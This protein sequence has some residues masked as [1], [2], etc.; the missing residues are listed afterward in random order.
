M[1]SHFLGK[2]RMEKSKEKGSHDMIKQRE[3]DEGIVVTRS[4]LRFMHSIQMN[5]YCLLFM[6]STSSSLHTAN[7]M[8][9]YK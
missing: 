2:R 3:R 4:N 1:K 7:I 6:L 8:Y 5:K 9:T